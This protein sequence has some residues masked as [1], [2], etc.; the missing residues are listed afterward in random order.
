M[1][2]I[3]SIQLRNNGMTVNLA[4][5]T[6]ESLAV[7]GPNFSNAL[8][9]GGTLT[10]TNGR[11]SFT[12]LLANYGDNSEPYTWSFNSIG[13]ATTPADALSF[14]QN[15]Q[16]GSSGATITLWDGVNTPPTVEI[17]PD[18][19][20]LGSSVAT[21]FTATVTDPDGGTPSVTWSASGGTPTTGRG[22]TIL[23][24]PPA[25]TL[26]EQTFTITATAQDAQR[27]MA[28][29]TV[30]VTLVA[31]RP[32]TVSVSPDAVT[33]SSSGATTFTATAAD[34]D[35]SAPS[36][37]WAADGGTPRT[38]SG[39]SLT[40]T[41][42]AQT[43]AAQ[44]FRVTATARDALG[45]TATA[46][47]TVTLSAKSGNDPPTISIQPTSADLTAS[48]PTTF[49]A[50]ADNPDGAPP[51]VTWA[52]DGGTPRTGSGNSLTWTPPA[53]TPAV[54]TFEVTATARDP[55]GAT[56]SATATVTLSGNNPPT[57]SVAPPTVSLASSE[58][59]TFF[60]TATDPDGGSPTVTWAADGGT[61]RSGT[62]NTFRWTPPAK[63]NEL[64]TF[65]IT[66]TARDVRGA[67][68]SAAARATLQAILPTATPP[69][70][71][72]DYSE[73][74]RQPLE[75]LFSEVPGGSPVLVG[76][77]L[78][79]VVGGIM[80]IGRGAAWSGPAAAIGAVAA[81]GT[82]N[83][84][85]QVNSLIAAVIIILAL[86]AGLAFFRASRAR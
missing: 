16:S 74:G 21:R 82:L 61:P 59:I 85:G 17:T 49:T 5:S 84:M 41:P 63:S 43:D 55:G 9:T 73:G 68:A 22:N 67:T 71:V 50:T 1:A 2:Y 56:A 14:Y 29:D 77:V 11:Y 58:P 51:T 78:L 32:P 19:L 40:W 33:L 34:P 37:S 15:F 42:P 12:M 64:Q 10:M 3:R 13:G 62:G 25:Q 86:L 65:T 8:L 7:I 28:T 45:A 35:G 76:A 83:A 30:T 6:T 36:V 46:T 39:N 4:S 70:R 24:T 52:V 31:N 23:W 79:M 66:A 27:A 47:A 18:D 57:V 69:P 81:I 38:G 80:L 72:P 44:T 48:V 54:Q 26:Q 75:Y 60:A 53:Q 20:E